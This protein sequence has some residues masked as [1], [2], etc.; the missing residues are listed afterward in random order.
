[1]T[2]G[3]VTGDGT[4]GERLRRDRLT[5]GLTQEELAE[6]SGLSVRTIGDLERG[7]G[8]PRMSTLRRLTDALS[9]PTGDQPAAPASLPRE[10]P[11]SPAL[12]VG[13]SRELATL[14][15]F[16]A[17]TPTATIISAIGGT[18]G[19][20]KTA[21]ALRW[22][23]EHAPRFPDGQLY[24]D[25]RG[26]DPGPPVSAQEA[27]SGFLRSLGVRGQDVPPNL[28]ECAA[29][30][31]SLL[32][33]RRVLVLLDNA[34][35]VEQVRPLLP[36]AVGCV[37]L[38]TSRDALA[39]LVARDGARRLD[40]ELL[41]PPEAI[42]LL[43][44]LIG[45]R[46]LADPSAVEALARQCA[47]LPLALRVA[48]EL[49]C[50]RRAVPL[51][52]LADELA[53]RHRMLDL[54][55]AG[56]DQR[57]AVRAVFSWSYQHLGL[58][59][60]QSFRLLGLH[61]GTEFEPYG[62]AALTGGTV[63]RASQVLIDLSRAHLVEPAGE[64]TYAMH[65]LLRAYAAEQAA[66]AETGLVRQE[67]MTRLFDFYLG[68]TAMAMD[69]L[70]PIEEARAASARKPVV[71]V[72]VTDTGSARRWLAANLTTLVRVVGTAAD[73]GWT[74]HAISLA[75][76]MFR[77]LEAGN[78]L[79]EIVT[80]F[81]HAE[82]AATQ[83]GD[84]RAQAQALNN[85]CLTHLRQGDYQQ[86]RTLLGRS[87]ELYLQS[88][89][90]TGQAYALGN[91][92]IIEYIEG[93]YEQALTSQHLALARYRQT[94]G[95]LGEARTLTNIGLVELRLEEFEQAAGYFQRSLELG[96]RIGAQL[97]Q[98]LALAGLGSA[99]LGQGS[100]EAADRCLDDA[101]A[102]LREVGDQAGEA[103]A[104]SM[105]GALRC[106]QNRPARALLLQRE[107]LA[108]YRK[109]G[110]PAGQALALNGMA[111]A[112]LATGDL[113]QAKAS[114]TA[115]L[116]LANRVGDK[117]EQARSQEYLARLGS[118]I[119]SAAVVQSATST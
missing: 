54:L 10:L 116:A 114:A 97:T 28:A 41:A 15:E 32:A 72:P 7:R 27:L 25:L 47:G 118:G 91:L 100:Y 58:A 46:A 35:D 40:L 84:R 44:A 64:A 117:H 43:R 49:V 110:D 39:G 56:G 87:L 113:P 37:T 95:Q 21:L 86:A 17:G 3:A 2:G 53:D 111:Q 4:F 76:V 92:G 70:F 23:H 104:L 16:C 22:A 52:T 119:S 71:P 79:S 78:H 34:R 33:G 108:L 74:D 42:S 11:A 38:V 5:A 50:A 68:T 14:D 19:V 51:A 1:M 103:E 89:D 106:A 60:A 101:L 112:L 80:V 20:G 57:T 93:N 63:E 18:A 55:D 59:C 83:A 31:R 77:Y 73:Q 8:Q 24:V 109:I 88:E 115:A 12:F 26:Y 81:G 94:D 29:R 13:R 96:R 105:L 9:Q 65:D 75:D 45:V 98:G 90:V 48:A 69:I 36:G 62:L 30:Y 61:P 6:R 107:S 99:R 102:L 82:R 67:A 85:L 66:T